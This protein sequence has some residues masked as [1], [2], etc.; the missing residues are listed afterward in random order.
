MKGPDCEDLLQRISTNDVLSLNSG[1][2]VQTILTNERGRI[3]DVVVVVKLPHGDL[4]VSGQST[5]PERVLE[6]LEKFIIMEDVRVTSVI[7]EYRHVIVLGQP[8]KETAGKGIVEFKEAL[9]K[10]LL[11]HCIVPTAH[12]RQFLEDVL[13]KSAAPMDRNDYESFRI[14]SRIPAW[15]FELSENFNPLEARLEQLVSW[16]KGCYVGQEVIA[17]LDTYKKVQKYLTVLE[18]SE[19]PEEIPVRMFRREEE[20][21]VLTSVAEGKGEEGVHGL[22]YVKSDVKPGE[23]LLVKSGSGTLE[24]KVRG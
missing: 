5:E 17:R 19:R 21:G 10:A 18:C 11:Q 2:P 3:I 22:G 6:W 16:T 20:A 7:R 1:H 12:W 4:L 13:E 14:E 24:A 9:G 15:P 23:V 8:L